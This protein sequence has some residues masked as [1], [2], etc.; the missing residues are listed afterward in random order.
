[1]PVQLYLTHAQKIGKKTQEI[2]AQK[3]WS[4]AHRPLIQTQIRAVDLPLAP[5]Y[6]LSSATAIHFL[7]HH[8]LCSKARYLTIG[9]RTL[10][11]AYELLPQGIHASL[12]AAEPSENGYSLPSLVAQLPEKKT[13]WLGSAQGLLRHQ[14]LFDSHRWITPLITHWTWPSLSQGLKLCWATPAHITCHCQNAALVLSQLSL[15]QTSVIWLSS[16]R[17]IR[18]FDNTRTIKVISQ[19]WVSDIEK[20]TATTGE[21]QN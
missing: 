14:N 2:L 18:F 6:I 4:W 16:P 9:Q 20:Y 21:N 15:P 3:G 7:Q 17:L 11:W 5:Q 19:D 1:M 13:I 8:K 12:A 10:E